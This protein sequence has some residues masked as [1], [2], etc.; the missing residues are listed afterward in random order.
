MNELVRKTKLILQCSIRELHYDL[1]KSG[2]GLLRDLVVVNAENLVPDTM[3]R[4]L[5]PKEL[6][7]MTNHYKQ[8]CFPGQEVEAPSRKDS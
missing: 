8:M 3:F 4:A 2:S 1:H 5:L 6:R 7:V